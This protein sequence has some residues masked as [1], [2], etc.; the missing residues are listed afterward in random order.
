MLEG[1]GF[2]LRLAEQAPLTVGGGGEAVAGV[3][4]DQ[5]GRPGGEC[6]ASLQRLGHGLGRGPDAAALA[7]S[8]GEVAR[9]QRG[10]ERVVEL[11]NH[12][13]DQHQ[14]ADPL[15]LGGGGEREHR[16]AHRVAGGDD[17]AQVALREPL[18]QI[19]GHLAPGALLRRRGVLRRAVAAHVERED[20][21]GVGQQARDGVPGA[22]VEAGRVDEQRGRL[23]FAARGPLPE[24]QVKAAHL[25][26]RGGRQRARLS[27]GH[28]LAAA[29]D[30]AAA[31]AERVVAPFERHLEPLFAG[32]FGEL[33]N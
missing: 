10:R 13:V 3:G 29:A 19:F 24:A 23:G 31:V 16:A 9:R 12:R 6:A 27:V 11:G 28:Q 21:P 1:P 30:C 33:V 25:R 32:D 4:G 22:R 17:S 7:G 20:A 18:A 2:D 5:I 8:F 26:G 14:R 15:R